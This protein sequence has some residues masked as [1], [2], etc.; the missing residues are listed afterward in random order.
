M[1][2]IIRMEKATEVSFSSYVNAAYGGGMEETMA[3]IKITKHNL[4]S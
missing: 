1:R 4:N 2:N 3:S